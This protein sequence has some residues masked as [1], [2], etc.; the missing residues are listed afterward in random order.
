M[1]EFFKTL[2]FIGRVK[3]SR[4]GG[5]LNAHFF[6][7]RKTGA[8]SLG[9][10]KLVNSEC[11]IILTRWKRDHPCTHTASTETEQNVGSREATLVRMVER[12]APNITSAP[13]H[14]R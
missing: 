10:V 7:V 2:I 8:G 3:S 14:G 4:R 9:Q 1:F 5:G 12:H 13:S 11:Q 6:R